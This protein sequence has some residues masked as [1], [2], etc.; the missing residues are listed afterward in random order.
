MNFAP[1]YSFS[2]ALE[3]IGPRRERDSGRGYD[4]RAKRAQDVHKILSDLIRV[5]DAPG[6]GFRRRSRNCCSTEAARESRSSWINPWMT[7]FDELL[8]RYVDTHTRM[9]TGRRKC[10]QVCWSIPAW[11]VAKREV[12]STPNPPVSR[13]KGACREGKSF[14]HVCMKQRDK[15]VQLARNIR[16]PTI[17][18]Q[19]KTK[20][21]RWEAT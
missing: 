21:T 17:D 8:S 14:W 12:P 20:L 5:P 3:S 18:V 1:T 4:I 15:W 11:R 19:T 9:H 10:V 13:Q 7:F 2:P 16:I 6:G